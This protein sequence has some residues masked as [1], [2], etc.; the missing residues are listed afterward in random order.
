MI[1]SNQIKCNK[2]GDEIYSAHR[3]DYVKCG[4]KSGNAMVDGGMDYMR[5]GGDYTEMSI[6]IPDK[7]YE[8]CIEAIEWAE[9]TGRNELGMICA[10]FRAFR[11]NNMRLEEV[12]IKKIVY[13]QELRI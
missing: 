9:D 5:R 6:V 3:H 1:L 7:V 13:E 4:C 10:I 11:D 2:C 12:Q 8:D